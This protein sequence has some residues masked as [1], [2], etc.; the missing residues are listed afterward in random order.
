MSLLLRVAANQN[1][2][3]EKS[4]YLYDFWGPGHEEMSLYETQVN[5]G[6]FYFLW[7]AIMYV[8]AVSGVHTLLDRR[9][10]AISCGT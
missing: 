1:I 7:I 5:V 2:Y 6:L 9:W 4:R 3:S 8:R 10:K